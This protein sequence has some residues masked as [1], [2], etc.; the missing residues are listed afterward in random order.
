MYRNAKRFLLLLPVLLLASCSKGENTTPGVAGTTPQVTTP[1]PSTTT[2]PDSQPSKSG[3]TDEIFA[4]FKEGFASRGVYRS[5]TQSVG[6]TKNVVDTY[7]TSK[8][9]LFVEYEAVSDSLTPSTTT[10]SQKIRYVSGQGLM[11]P[12]YQEELGLDNKVHTY[13]VVDTAGNSLAWYQ[14]GYANVFA[15]VDAEDFVKTDKENVYALNMDDSTLSVVYS[16]L[17]QQLVGYMGL[18]LQSFEVRVENGTL[19]TYDAVFEPYESSYG[20]AYSS[21]SGEF[22]ASGKDAYP[23]LKPVEGEEDELFKTRL[24]ALKANNFKAHVSTGGREIDVQVEDG[25]NVVYDIEN[26]NGSYLGNYGYYQKVEGFVQGVIRLKD[27]FYPDGAPLS[28]AISSLLPTFNISSLFFDKSETDEGTL[29]TMKEELPDITVYTSDYGMLAGSV[30]GELSILITDKTV[31][32]KNTL[33]N[34]EEKFVYSDEG[35]VKDILKDLQKNGDSLTWTILASNQSDELAKLLT[36]VPEEALDQIPVPGGY[37]NNVVLDASYRPNQPVFS[38]TL[39]DY[40]EG[41]D[42]METMASKLITA[43]FAPSI[44]KG[45]HNGD[46]YTKEVTAAGEAKTLSVEIYL[47]ADYFVSPQFLV[48]PS[49]S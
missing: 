47:A 32:I 13:N 34:G 21:I 19:T 40:A 42:L 29:Y 36:L 43:G 12:L 48:Y 35:S 17:P 15:Y 22:T 2:T 24:D 30:A 33:I 31:E 27:K 28:G 14:A 46:L 38:F 41:E 6:Y 16:R 49:L 45:A 44:D 9:F 39:S 23:E 26:K 8:A 7:A 20:T 37:Y 25:T 5:G 18:T 11:A 3:L 1:D 10:I 4:P